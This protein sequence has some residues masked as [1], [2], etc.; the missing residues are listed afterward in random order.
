MDFESLFNEYYEKLLIENSEY[1]S[2]KKVYF[3]LLKEIRY[4]HFMII[5]EIF[6]MKKEHL[7]YE[8]LTNDKD[9]SDIKNYFNFLFCFKEIDFILKK[10][11]EIILLINSLLKDYYKENNITLEKLTFIDTLLEIIMDTYEKDL[12]SFYDYLE[13]ITKA[14]DIVV[15]NKNYQIQDLKTFIFNQ[16]NSL[17]EESFNK[18]YKRMLTI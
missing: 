2:N 1:K 13:E 18:Y 15:S 9:L 16:I 12:D 7:Y 10:Y 6:M 4:Y 5:K 14:V 3:T 17:D 8:K 11:I